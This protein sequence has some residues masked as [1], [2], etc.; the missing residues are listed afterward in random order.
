M[1]W[2]N[3]NLSDNYE[4]NQNI[5]DPFSF[6]TLLLE[7]SCNLKEVTPE[8]V[9]AQFTESMRSRLQSATEVFA[10]N[11]DNIVAKALEEKNIDAE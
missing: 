8:T 2:K 10:A 11:L 6:D 1:D 9:K 4:V 5:L 7:I 3:V